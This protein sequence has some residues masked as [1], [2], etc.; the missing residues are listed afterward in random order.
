MMRSQSRPKKKIHLFYAREMQKAMKPCLV[1]ETFDVVH[2][3]GDDD[4]VAIQG[5]LDS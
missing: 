1:T 3:V 2:A 4:G 5:A